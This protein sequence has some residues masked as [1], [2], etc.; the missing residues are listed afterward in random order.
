MSF[1][2]QFLIAPVNIVYPSKYCGLTVRI[3]VVCVLKA[4]YHF[5][6][7]TPFEKQEFDDGTMLMSYVYRHFL[8]LTIYKR[9]QNPPCGVIVFENRNLNAMMHEMFRNELGR[10][11]PSVMWLV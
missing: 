10:I 9:S 6:T 3:L 11:P 1:I 7:Q 2:S 4:Y 8:V 5:V